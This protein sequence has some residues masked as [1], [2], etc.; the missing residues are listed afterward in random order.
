MKEKTMAAYKAGAKTVLVPEANRKD[1]P[2]LDPVVKENLNFIFCN[3]L[4]DAFKNV[5][6]RAE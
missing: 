6:V 4:D 1:I 2:E 5:L 3:T